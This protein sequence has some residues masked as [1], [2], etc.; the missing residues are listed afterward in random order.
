[1]PAIG[2]LWNALVEYHAAGLFWAGALLYQRAPLVPTIRLFH[3]A[4]PSIFTKRWWASGRLSG[5]MGLPTGAD[6]I[7]PTGGREGVSPACYRIPSL[8]RVDTARLLAFAEARYGS[9]GDHARVGIAMRVSIDRGASWSP[10]RFPVPAT[11]VGGNPT[12][13]VDSASDPPT[14]HLYYVRG[15]DLWTIATADV[16]ATWSSPRNLSVALGPY[17]GALPGPGRALA[18]PRGRFVVPL[19][20]GTAQRDDGRVVIL[21]SDD[22]GRTYRLASMTPPD[23]THRMDE[24]TLVH[25]RNETLAMYMRTAGRACMCKARVVSGDEGRSWTG[26][27]RNGDVVYEP[28]LADPVCEASAAGGSAVGHLYVAGPGARHARTRLTLW[29][30]AVAEFDPSRPS[31]WTPTTL[32]DATVFTGYTS[33]VA[34]PST[35][36][37]ASGASGASGASMSGSAPAPTGGVLVSVLWEGCRYPLPFRVWCFGGWYVAMSAVWVAGESGPVA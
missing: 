11:D 35:A 22:R 26:G 34:W 4:E 10:V 23:L 30:T 14:T 16:G 3:S 21:H 32:T 24:A 37:E 13:L 5:Q 31:V 33:T 17:R 12:T 9:C 1:M 20:F 15:V 7:A 36:Q 18:S 29:T 19:H 6:T 28:V 2:L 27:E 25:V 8:A